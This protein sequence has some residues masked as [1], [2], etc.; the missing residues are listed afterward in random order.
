MRHVRP[1]IWLALSCI[2]RHLMAIFWATPKT[3][4]TVIRVL[5]TKLSPI[6]TSSTH[7]E[8][9]TLMKTETLI[10]I[11]QTASVDQ[12]QTFGMLKVRNLF[13]QSVSYTWYKNKNNP[14]NCECEEIR[15]K[16]LGPF[17]KVSQIKYC[18]ELVFECYQIHLHH[19]CLFTKFVE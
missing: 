2:Q 18:L 17:S 19:F 12:M 4:T 1:G 3:I 15:I 13:Y 10:F 6:L 9:V 8:L 5:C 16:L 7:S 14:T 11:I